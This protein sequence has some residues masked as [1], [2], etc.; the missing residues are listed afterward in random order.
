MAGFGMPTD[1]NNSGQIV[2]ITQDASNTAYAFMYS[3]GTYSNLG[4]LGGNINV[5]N[6]TATAIN[7]SGQVTGE[8]LFSGNAGGHAFIYTPGSGMAD[9]GTV[10]GVDSE[11][12]AINDSGQVAGVSQTS[13]GTYHAVVATA[14][15]G[16]TDIGTLGGTSSTAFGIN[17]SGEVT[18]T[19]ETLVGENNAFIYTPDLGMTDLGTLGGE[20]SWGYGINN[21]GQ[22]T[23][24]SET[25]AGQ[26][27]AFIY[28]PG[29]GMADLGTL[30][31]LGSYGESI[32]DLG[33]VVGEIASTGVGNYAM[34]DVDGVMYDLS[35]LHLAQLRI[36][37]IDPQHS[38]KVEALGPL[39][40]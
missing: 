10:G 1:I 23:G 31:G 35:W 24:Y 29:V 22:V 8:S 32:N 20:E 11:G 36:E 33:Q 28:T 39:E 2:G 13:S 7:G 38:V 26:V 9:L 27:D 17:N 16:M 34:L 19:S 6:L 12:L 5:S 18:G 21:S 40:A 3:S 15:G 30:Y 25:L 4:S 14:G 37:T